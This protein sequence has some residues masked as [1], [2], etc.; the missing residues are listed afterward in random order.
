[1][2]SPFHDGS[3]REIDSVHSPRRYAALRRGPPPTVRIRRGKMLAF[4][5]WGIDE[6]CR[7]ASQR[8]AF[9]YGSRMNKCRAGKVVSVCNERPARGSKTGSPTLNTWLTTASSNCSTSSPWPTPNRFPAPPPRATFPRRPCHRPSTN[10][11]ASWGRSCWS[12]TGPAGSCS[13]RWAPISSRCQGPGSPCRRSP[14][15]H[16]GTPKHPGRPAGHRRLHQ[17]FGVLVADHLRAVHQAQP[18]ARSAD[19]RGRRGRAAAADA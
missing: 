2:V 6:E 7:F 14:G 3:G 17:P 1:M 15:P 19:R 4:Q 5:C 9:G 13:P 18:R 12:G 11:N 16:R 8:G 10:S